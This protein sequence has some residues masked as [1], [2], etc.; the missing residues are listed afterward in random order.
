MMKFAGIGELLWDMDVKSGTRH[1]GGAPG[2]VAVHCHSHGAE[3]HVISK[4]GNDPLGNEAEENIREH[5]VNTEFLQKTDDFPTGVVE[6][7]VGERGIP[8]YEIKENAAWDHISY[9]PEINAFAGDLDAVCFGSL[10]QRHEHSRASIQSF[11]KATP[12][13]CL[14]V[15]DINLRLNYY[16]EETILQSLEL[17]NALKI[18]DEELPIVASISGLRG[19]DED[20]LRSL[21]EMYSLRLGILTYGP[22][23]AFLMDEN[24]SNFSPAGFAPH[25]ESTVG[26]GDSYTATTIMDFLNGK[27]LSEIN[28]HANDVASYV[29]TKKSATP[30]LPDELKC[31]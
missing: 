30:S 23:G 24:D 31:R 11:L 8:E 28:K 7:K 9:S 14:K 25:I 20:V 29:C 1:L 22:K 15:F 27:S 16:T 26:A 3:S 12:P 13:S 2:N 10:A 4:L 18:N 6:I 19:S 5:G 17:A 21:F